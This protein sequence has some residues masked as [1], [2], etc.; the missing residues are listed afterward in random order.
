MKAVVILYKTTINKSEKKVK[1]LAHPWILKKI[2]GKYA[3][4]Q[5]P[6]AEQQTSKINSKIFLD[7]QL[8][9]FLEMSEMSE[10]TEF[11]TIIL[12][13]ELNEVSLS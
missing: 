6:K 1:L 7:W 11:R 8:Q 13:L 9:E 10:V 3:S 2:A 12:T 4:V 5:N